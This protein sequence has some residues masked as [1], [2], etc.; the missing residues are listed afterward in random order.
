MASSVT[1]EYSCLLS[2]EIERIG[3]LQRDFLGR[4]DGWTGET[5]KRAE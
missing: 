3:Q 2:A 1:T 4:G 5:S